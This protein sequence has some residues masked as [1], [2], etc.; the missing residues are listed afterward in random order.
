MDWGQVFGIM[1]GSFLGS[2]IWDLFLR[3]RLKPPQ[4]PDGPVSRILQ[5]PTP[6]WS[7]R[8]TTIKRGPK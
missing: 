8:T 5:P 2:M 7:E 1:L 6:M 3:K 4:P